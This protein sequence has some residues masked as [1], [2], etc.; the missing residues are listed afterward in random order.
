MSNIT[1]ALNDI[2]NK[3]CLDKLELEFYEKKS[4][5]FQNERNAQTFK[6]Y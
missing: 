5:A 4:S 1:K 3:S 6:K 2:V